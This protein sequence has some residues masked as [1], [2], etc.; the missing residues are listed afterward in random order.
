MTAVDG[1]TWSEVELVLARA[2]QVE[3]WVP[4]FA[5]TTESDGLQ[6]SSPCRGGVARGAR[7]GMSPS[8]WHETP[9]SAL[10][11]ATSP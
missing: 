7:G 5:G 11:A 3:S 2:D 4:A 1:K 9:P 10:R 6:P 8:Q